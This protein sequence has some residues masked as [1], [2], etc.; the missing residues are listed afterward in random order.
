MDNNTPN[1]SAAGLQFRPELCII[2][3][4]PDIKNKKWKSKYVG[5][6]SIVGI[7]SLK[8]SA[9]MKDDDVAKRIKI[10]EVN[11]LFITTPMNVLKSISSRIPQNPEHTEEE[12]IC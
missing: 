4:K 5:C 8:R 6:L 7:N 12:T 9:E 11:H 1:L 2:C 10:L 3:Q